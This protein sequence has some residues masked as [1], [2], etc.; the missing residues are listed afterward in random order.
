MKQNQHQAGYAVLE[1]I[2][3][4]AVIALAAFAYTTYRA[5]IQARGNTTATTSA[6]LSAG[7]KAAAANKK[8]S[9]A[10]LVH[11]QAF[12]KTWLTAPAPTYASLEQ[13]GYI[14]PVALKAAT[15]NSYDLFTCSQN[16]LSYGEY[17]F[18]DPVVTNDTATM[19]VSGVY[20]G[21]P[22]S[23]MVIKLGLKQV[24]SVWQINSVSCPAAT[25][26]K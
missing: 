20:S 15:S 22:S 4:L 17:K 8:A 1:V 16:A 11:V 12:Y 14:T 25:A 10:A 23:T 26:S 18:S 24:G 3:V 19:L 9:Q 2:L 5:R 7:A 21:P 13:Q 6:A